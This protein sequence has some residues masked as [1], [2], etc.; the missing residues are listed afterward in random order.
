MSGVPRYA[1][2]VGKYARYVMQRSGAEGVNL[3]CH[4]M[5]CLISHYII[6]ND[7]EKLASEGKIRR[8][9]GTMRSVTGFGHIAKPSNGRRRAR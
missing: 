3:T 6:E 2:I 8:W 5:G 7:V 1:A 9:G 4:S